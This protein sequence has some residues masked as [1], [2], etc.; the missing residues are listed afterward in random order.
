MVS[1]YLPGETEGRGV[2]GCAEAGP[3]Q[4]RATGHGDG[5]GAPS[6]VVPTRIPHALGDRIFYFI[7]GSFTIGCASKR[8][9]L[10]TS[11]SAAHRIDEE[12]GGGDG[13][14]VERWRDGE[15]EV[16]TD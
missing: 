13:G 2:A 3:A 1:A 12:A 10:F 4:I 5:D 8:K 16:E 11:L 14:G 9:M 6:P 7:F 15:M